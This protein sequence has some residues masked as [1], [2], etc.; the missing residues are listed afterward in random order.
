MKL[1]VNHFPE[2]SPALRKTAPPVQ[3]AQDWTRSPP[4]EVKACS[5]L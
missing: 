5:H 4:P 3:P 1:V 2:K